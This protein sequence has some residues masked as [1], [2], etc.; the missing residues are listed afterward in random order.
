MSFI[1]ISIFVF[2]VPELGGV[3]AVIRMFVNS[4]GQIPKTSVTV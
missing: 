4:S 2:A 3:S 1:Q